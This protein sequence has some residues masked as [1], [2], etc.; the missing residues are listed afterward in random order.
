MT[1]AWAKDK[2]ISSVFSTNVHVNEVNILS[3]GFSTCKWSLNRTHTFYNFQLSQLSIYPVVILVHVK[4][5][6]LGST[7]KPQNVSDDVIMQSCFLANEMWAKRHND[8]VKF[9]VYIMT[10]SVNF[11]NL[12]LHWHIVFLYPPSQNEIRKHPQFTICTCK[13][14]SENILLKYF[15]LYWEKRCTYN[16]YV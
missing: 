2:K 1:G 9:Y 16:D 15:Q 5:L 4:G 10:D 6:Y 7:T 12:F 3:H 11:C 13:H 14:T 8:E